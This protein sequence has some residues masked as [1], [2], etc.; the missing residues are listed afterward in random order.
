MSGMIPPIPLPAGPDE[1]QPSQIEALVLAVTQLRER[2][3]ALEG[4]CDRVH[5]IIVESHRART[6]AKLGSMTVSGQVPVW[7]PGE[8]PQ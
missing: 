7:A 6:E 8:R 3:S 4:F 5:K 2:V 1:P